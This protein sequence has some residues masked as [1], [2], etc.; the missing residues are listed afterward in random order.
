MSRIIWLT[1]TTL[2][3]NTPVCEIIYY[4]N[5]DLHT[6]RNIY[7]HNSVLASYDTLSKFNMDTIIKT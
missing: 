6:P 7:L 3:N 4:A 1:K 2:L 5:L